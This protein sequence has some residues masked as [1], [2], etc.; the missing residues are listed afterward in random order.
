MFIR[1]SLRLNHNFSFLTVH[2]HDG[3]SSSLQGPRTLAAFNFSIT[4]SLSS[5]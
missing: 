3:F 2:G 5:G 4:I 1:M